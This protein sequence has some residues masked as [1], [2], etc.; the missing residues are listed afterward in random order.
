VSNPPEVWADEPDLTD[1]S[2]LFILDFGMLMDKLKIKYNRGPFD[3]ASF[4]RLT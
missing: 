3:V 4:K 1:H 2:D